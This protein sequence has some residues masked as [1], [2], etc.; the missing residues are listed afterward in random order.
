MNDVKNSLNQQ[1]LDTEV[2]VL[3]KLH[4]VIVLN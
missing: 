1:N 3:V 2:N 4:F